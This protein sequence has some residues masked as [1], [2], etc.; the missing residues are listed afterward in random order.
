RRLP[1]VA[2]SGVRA[3]WPRTGLAASLAGAGLAIAAMLAWPGDVPEPTPLPGHAGRPPVQAVGA[4][5]LA[6]WTLEVVPPAYTGLAAR[7]ADA[8]DVRVPE[9]ARLTWTL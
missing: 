9:G 3:H 4:P 6:A 5:R 8:L 7:Q 2:D 1:T